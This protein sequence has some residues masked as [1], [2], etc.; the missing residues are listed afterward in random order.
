MRR[1]QTIFLLS[2]L[3]ACLTLAGTTPLRHALAGPNPSVGGYSEEVGDVAFGVER[4]GRVH[5]LWTGRLNPHFGLFAFYAS[6]SDGVNWSPYQVLNYYDAYDPVVVIDND[7]G[8]AHLLYRSNADGIIHHVVNGATVSPP[9]IIAGRGVR[10]QAALD[11]ASGA[12]HAVWQEGGWVPL[13]ADSMAWLFRAWY[14]RW[15]G[16][17]WSP[18]R[19]VINSG[20][21]NYVSV[22]AAPGGRVML[23]WFQ[24][25]SASVGGATDPGRQIVIRTAYSSGSGSFALRQ[26]VSA[27]YPE[28]EKDSSILLTYAP[29]DNRFYIVADH[30]M[31]P[32]HSRVYRYVWDGAWHGPLDIVGNS[33]GWARPQ[34]IGAAAERPFVYYVYRHNDGLWARSESDGTLSAP[35]D[36]NAQLAGL[37]YEG[38]ATFFVDHD[39]GIHMAVTGTYAGVAGLYY[40]RP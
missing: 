39:G 13:Q 33:S 28:P 31:W 7:R 15:D 5:M 21:T 14:A 26:A 38:Q 35:Q 37:G 40:V 23:A 29:G 8:R 27:L 18:A 20:D 24:E 19:K 3:L 22:A 4:N 36:L 11:P 6:S 16:T 1:I 12:L 30:L 17:A 32:G 9:V 10:P 25:W 2:G 34:F